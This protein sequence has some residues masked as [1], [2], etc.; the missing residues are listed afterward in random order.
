MQS[1][2]KFHLHVKIF[3][4]HIIFTPPLSVNTH[5]IKETKKR[6]YMTHGL[7]MTFFYMAVNGSPLNALQIN[8][9]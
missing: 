6:P 1:I 3:S 4:P 7:Y 9:T 8:Y 2:G 5:N